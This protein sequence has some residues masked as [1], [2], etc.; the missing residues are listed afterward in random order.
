MDNTE[1]VYE[2]GEYCEVC[3]SVVNLGIW[4][5]HVTVCGICYKGGKFEAWLVVELERALA[6]S[7][8]FERL[9]NGGYRRILTK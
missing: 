2:E 3:G 8:D 7:A 6:A 9:P 5:D 1:P 4:D